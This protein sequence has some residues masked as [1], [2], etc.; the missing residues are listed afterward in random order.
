MRERGQR[1]RSE[2]DRLGLDGYVSGTSTPGSED[3]GPVTGGLKMTK[4][5]GNMKKDV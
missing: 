4:S 5:E 3:D 1:R 2:S